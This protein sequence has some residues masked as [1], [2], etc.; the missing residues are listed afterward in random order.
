MADNVQG[1]NH[2]D[3]IL[4]NLGQQFRQDA[5]RQMML[6]NQSDKNNI[7]AHRGQ[8]SGAF[9]NLPVNSLMKMRAQLLGF[10]EGEKSK[11]INSQKDVTGQTPSVMEANSYIE[12]TYPG[13]MAQLDQINNAAMGYLSKSGIMKGN[14]QNPGISQPRPEVQFNPPNPLGLDF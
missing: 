8:G 5:I 3:S 14:T 13:E 6:K 1:F 4:M 12:K 2:L 7:L 11:F 10:I 9:S